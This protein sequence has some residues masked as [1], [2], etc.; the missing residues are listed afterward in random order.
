MLEFAYPAV[1]LGAAAAAGAVWWLYRRPE[2]PPATG[3]AAAF[4]WHDA[5]RTDAEASH[6]VRRDRR[7]VLRAA[8]AVA[9]GTAVAGPRWLTSSPSPMVVWIDD[10]PSLLAVDDGVVRAESLAER[11]AA[12]LREAA[13][14]EAEF[15]SLRQPGRHLRLDRPEAAAIRAWIAPTESPPFL[16]LTGSA[17]ATGGIWLATDGADGRIASWIETVR[18]DRIVQTG[19]ETENVAVSAV[20]VRRP[21]DGPPG[22]IGF[23]EIVNAGDGVAHRAVRL[24]EASGAEI[25]NTEIVI[26]PGQTRRLSFQIEADATRIRA[27]VAPADALSRDDSL[28]L[29]LEAAR[30]IATIVD[31]ACGEA[32]RAALAAHPGLRM[33]DAGRSNALRV[34]CHPDATADIELHRDGPFEAVADPPAW[35]AI[36]GALRDVRLDRSWVRVGSTA[37]A[38]D[39]EPLLMAGDKTLIR[40]EGGRIVSDLDLDDRKLTRRPAFPAL[41][42][43]LLDR[44]AGRALLDPLVRSER[45]ADSLRIAPHTF[46]D[47]GRP[48]PI[49]SAAAPLTLPTLLAAL[50]LL[51]L[52]I[53][54]GVRSRPRR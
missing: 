7:W 23:V 43:G 18:P 10:G 49:A 32:V 27:T 11:V 47:P 38:L 51:G 26:E 12:K 17:P 54:L 41:L 40:A 39:G 8:I 22:F 52:D 44:V 4:L 9:I 45:A 6:L 33:A 3:V 31:A 53:A 2:L 34:A 19:S 50:A 28:E 5:E 37:R 14:P 15:R 29:S 20:A 16:P 21:W 24:S 13:V 46:T 30:P 1:L 48:A 35:R 25:L 36:A 42:S